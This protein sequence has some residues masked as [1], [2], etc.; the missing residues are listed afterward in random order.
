MVLTPQTGQWALEA[1]GLP[2]L[3]NVLISPP[4]HPGEGK[5][6]AAAPHPAPR[7][8]APCTGHFARDE[9]EKPGPP[10]CHVLALG[11][12]SDSVLEKRRGL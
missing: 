11:N 3:R 12:K 2:A 5:G 7:L 6:H 1:H 4:P 8:Q 9:K 10:R